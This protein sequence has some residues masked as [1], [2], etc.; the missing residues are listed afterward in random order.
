V[1]IHLDR[2]AIKALYIL[3]A[4]VMYCRTTTVP[5][6]AAEPSRELGRSPLGP[7]APQ[8]AGCA[9]P[10]SEGTSG[11]HSRPTC[12][13]MDI[14]QACRSGNCNADRH[15]LCRSPLHYIQGR[16]STQPLSLRLGCA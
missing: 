5:S 8:R 15:V 4:L 3:S 16:K 1:S 12:R 2:S 14:G 9:F 7:L 11:C 10:F 6:P 13:T